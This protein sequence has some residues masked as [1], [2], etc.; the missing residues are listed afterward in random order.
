M[1]TFWLYFDNIMSF[2]VA[3]SLPFFVCLFLFGHAHGMCK[4]PGQG[5]NP[6]C[7]SILSH[8]NDNTESLTC[9]T[10]RKL[11]P[12]HFLIKRILGLGGNTCYNHISYLSAFI[13]VFFFK[14]PKLLYEQTTLKSLHFLPYTL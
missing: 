13:H 5:S 14:R 3:L 11:H 12:H 6:P 7:S 8:C 9:C 1:T 4:F 10:T 2:L